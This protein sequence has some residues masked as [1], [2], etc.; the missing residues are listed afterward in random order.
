MFQSSVVMRGP[1]R[2]VIFVIDWSWSLFTMIS[3]HT[4]AIKLQFIVLR[5]ALHIALRHALWFA[6]RLFLH[7]I[8]APCLVPLI[9][10]RS[11]ARLSLR[12]ALS[13]PL[14]VCFFLRSCCLLFVPRAA[15][16]APLV[17]FLAQHFAPLLCPVSLFLSP[18]RR[19]RGILVAP[20]FCPA[21]SVRRHV[22][23]WAPKR[24]KI[25]WSIFI[26]YFS[27]MG[28]CKW[29][30]KG[31]NKIQNGRQRFTPF[32]FV[33]AKTLTLK[34]RNYSNFTITFPTIWGCAG[35]FKSFYWN[36]KWLPWITS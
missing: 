33:C 21:S 30:F 19:G 25:V 5:L 12:L 9:S 27:H 32:F 22:F 3:D 20:V 10:M 1:L 28:M 34:V 17:M 7:C 29:F 36:S 8:F 31:A 11:M 13:T 16:C 2:C 18:A 35:D 4:S 14:A 23:L 6:P 26:F 15:S 24:K